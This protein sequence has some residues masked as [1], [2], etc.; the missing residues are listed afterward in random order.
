MDKEM[1]SH[2]NGDHDKEALGLPFGDIGSGSTVFTTHQ[3]KTV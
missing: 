1:G 3:G 2:E